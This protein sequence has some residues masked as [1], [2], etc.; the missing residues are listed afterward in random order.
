MTEF[1]LNSMLHNILLNNLCRN[2][3]FY[4]PSDIFCNSYCSN[5]HFENMSVLSLLSGKNYELFSFFILVFQ[6][7]LLH[8]Y[9]T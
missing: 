4:S 9:Y 1:Q 5:I 3:N 2:C 8:I 6:L 7:L